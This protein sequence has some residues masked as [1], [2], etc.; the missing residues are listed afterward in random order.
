M[1]N[2]NFFLQFCS[3]WRS[4]VRVL[5]GLDC[6][7]GLFRFQ[8]ASVSLSLKAGKGSGELVEVP[9]LLALI[10]FMIVPAS[11]VTSQRFYLLMASALWV[12][13]PWVT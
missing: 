6:G 3:L 1:N 8:M 4:E 9:I 2:G 10:S 13:S 12:R 7:E 11:Y 5:V